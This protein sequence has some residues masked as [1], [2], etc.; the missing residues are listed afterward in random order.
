M[1]SSEEKAVGAHMPLIFS[2]REDREDI[3]LSIDGDEARGVSG[4]QQRPLCI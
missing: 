3:S 4:V 1:A 2:F